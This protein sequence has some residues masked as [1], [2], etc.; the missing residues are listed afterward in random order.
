MAA[1]KDRLASLTALPKQIGKAKGMLRK[2]TDVAR[3]RRTAPRILLGLACLSLLRRAVIGFAE[4]EKTIK[5][6]VLFAPSTPIIARAAGALVVEELLK[7]VQLA[8]VSNVRGEP[9]AVIRL[10]GKSG[11]YKAGDLVGSFTLKEVFLD[12]VVLVLDGQ[13]VELGR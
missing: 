7:K 3:I 8:G 11:L 6:K 10:N 12:K 9:A 4:A 5:S 1:L 13:L 2:T